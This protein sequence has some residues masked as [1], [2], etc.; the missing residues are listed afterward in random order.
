M[1]FR[2][3][4]RCIDLLN[5]AWSMADY[6]TFQEERVRVP[7]T[8]YLHLGTIPHF[9]KPIR[10]NGFHLL[11]IVLSQALLLQDWLDVG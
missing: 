10:S 8:S 6:S 5:A 7:R 3:T 9:F 2:A 11:L 1:L 4:V